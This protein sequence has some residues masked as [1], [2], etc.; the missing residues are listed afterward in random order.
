M[1]RTCPVDGCGSPHDTWG[2]VAVHLWKKEDPDHDHVKSKDGGLEYLAR[3]GHIGGDTSTDTAGEGGAD[4]DTADTT[5]ATATDGG[6]TTL[7]V[8][9][10][11][12]DTDTAQTDETTQREAACPECGRTPDAAAAYGS[13]EYLRKAG[14]R[15]PP[16]TAD[17][18]A[19]HEYVCTECWKGFNE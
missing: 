13:D 10:D 17:A 9:N 12:E 15:L 16:D 2:G 1:N 5:S 18:I 7:E 3:E 14:D 4:T 19:S 8:P 11:S 6:A